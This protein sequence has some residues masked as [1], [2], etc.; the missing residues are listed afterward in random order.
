VKSAILLLLL[1]LLLVH[2]RTCNSS[3]MSAC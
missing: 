2:C 3:K 1:L